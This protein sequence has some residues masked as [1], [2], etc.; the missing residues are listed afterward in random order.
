MLTTQFV[1]FQNNPQSRLQPEIC[2]YFSIGHTFVLSP[3]VSYLEAQV[4]WNF[5]SKSLDRFLSSLQM[6]RKPSHLAKSQVSSVVDLGIYRASLTSLFVFCIF[7]N[8]Y[9][10]HYM[11]CF[12]TY[13]QKAVRIQ[14][15]HY[16]VDAWRHN[17]VDVGNLGPS[18]LWSHLRKQRQKTPQVTW[19]RRRGQ[20][21]CQVTWLKIGDR[22]RVQVVVFLVAS[23]KALMSAYKTR[24]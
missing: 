10:W 18:D 21:T 19:D 22:K 17:S 3:W 24:A 6:T 23:E 16:S 9:M 14:W 2:I 4:T 7:L 12:T 13:L 20:V 8:Q 5:S 11:V 1:P 15:R